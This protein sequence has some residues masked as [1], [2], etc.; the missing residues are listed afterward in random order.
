MPDVSL[1]NKAFRGKIDFLSEN[2]MK[3]FTFEHKSQGKHI[4]EI[5]SITQAGETVK[6]GIFKAVHIHPLGRIRFGRVN[7]S[8]V[9]MNFLVCIYKFL[10]LEFLF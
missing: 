3:H 7:K 2:I 6:L 9:G 4:K 5:I 8:T 10:E 1:T